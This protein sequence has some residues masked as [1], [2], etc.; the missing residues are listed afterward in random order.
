MARQSGTTV[1]RAEFAELTEPD[2]QRPEL[3][4]RETAV[5]EMA[6]HMLDPVQLGIPVRSVDS[7]HV[8]VRWM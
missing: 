5:G 8:L 1:D 4:E 3:V 2:R 6:G 7:F